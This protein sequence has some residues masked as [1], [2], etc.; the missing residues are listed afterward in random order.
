M[1][2][3]MLLIATLCCALIFDASTAQS[4]PSDVLFPF[5]LLIFATAS[6]NWA[7]KC[8]ADP[9]VGR[10]ITNGGLMTSTIW[11]AMTAY[12]HLLGA[13][14]VPPRFV[15]ALPF[16]LQLPIA[17]VVAAAILNIP[18]LFAYM[19]HRQRARV[20]MIENRQN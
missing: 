3:T 7:S 14:I 18:L 16:W 19:A 8:F 10:D 20:G 15:S 1:R 12:L 11:L 17:L 13:T 4:K 6:R 9:K 5:V 2:I